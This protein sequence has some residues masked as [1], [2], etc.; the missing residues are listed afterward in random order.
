MP[1]AAQKAG[2]EGRFE[3]AES[4]G[5]C[6]DRQR[7]RGRGGAACPPRRP[8]AES[9]LRCGARRPAVP[10][11]LADQADDRLWRV[12]V[13]RSAR[14]GVERCGEQVSAGVPR[15]RTRR[16]HD[17]HLLT[18]TSGLPDMLPD[19]TELRASTRPCRSSW[20]EPVGRRCFSNPGRKSATRAWASCWPRRSSRRSAASRCRDSWRGRSFTHC[21][22]VKRRWAW[23][24]DRS[25]IPP[26]ARCRKPN[27]VIGTGTARTGG[28]SEPHGAALMPLRAIWDVPGSLRFPRWRGVAASHM[29]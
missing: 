16:G 25:R 23:A 22:C 3:E 19:N 20:L 21:A 15:R 26:S 1:V 7:R 24:V 5:T 2:L 9:R 11:R 4:V 17:G 28:T 29:P 8:G 12:V 27:A 18:H 14:A 10:D 6:A 13:T